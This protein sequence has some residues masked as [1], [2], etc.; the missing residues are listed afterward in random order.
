MARKRYEIIVGG[1]LGPRLAT[2]ISG[3]EVVATGDGT[4][5]L[6]GRADQAALYGALHRV[7]DLGLELVAVH[8]IA[9]SVTN[10]TDTQA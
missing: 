8:E 1:H 4:T 10:G 5:R 2:A 3:F 6:V 9:D 7:S